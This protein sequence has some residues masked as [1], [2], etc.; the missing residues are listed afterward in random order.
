M[1]DRATG[2]STS[3]TGFPFPVGILTGMMLPVQKKKKIKKNEKNVHIFGNQV[4]LYLNVVFESFRFMPF[5]K[6]VV[7]IRQGRKKRLTEVKTSYE[8]FETLCF[9]RF[10]KRS[11]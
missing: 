3:A 4:T 11:I 9:V 6:E 7:V 5:V 2:S 8:V 10:V 1:S